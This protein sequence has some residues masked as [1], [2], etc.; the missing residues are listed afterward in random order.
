[1]LI[2]FKRKI[3]MQAV[4]K[5]KNNCRYNQ[6]VDNSIQP[7]GRMRCCG[8]VILE[9]PQHDQALINCN[10]MRNNQVKGRGLGQGLANGEGQGVANGQGPRVGNGRGNGRG[11]GQNKVNNNQP[12]NTNGQGIGCGRNQGKGRGLGNG[13]GLGKGQRQ[14]LATNQD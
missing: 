11:N 6:I 9:Q 14:I 7:A 3:I 12:Q 1:M 4:N 8:Q 10:G 13:R 2:N 5:R